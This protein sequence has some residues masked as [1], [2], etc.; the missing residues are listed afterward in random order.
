MK[1]LQRRLRKYMWRSV[2]A[3]AAIGAQSPTSSTKPQSQLSQQIRLMLS[4]VQSLRTSHLKNSATEDKL[5]KVPVYKCGDL[6]G[7][8]DLTNHGECIEKYISELKNI[9]Y[10]SFRS[11]ETHAG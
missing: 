4:R 10:E 6:E 3:A 5:L 9:E 1:A 11:Q 2:K 8:S 7:D